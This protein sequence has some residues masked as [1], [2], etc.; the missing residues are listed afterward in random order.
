VED[1]QTRVEVL[2]RKPSE[3]FPNSFLSIIQQA[4]VKKN[5][6]KIEY[7]SYYNEATTQREIEPIGISHYGEGW[8]LIAYCHLRQDY[9]DFRADRIKTLAATGLS[10]KRQHLSLQDYLRQFTSAKQQEEAI[11]LFDQSVVRF[12]AEQKYIYGF[13]KEEQTGKMVR[14]YFRTAYM[15]S[16]GRWLLS[17]GNAVQ[18]EKP[19]RLIEIMLQ[20]AAE[21]HEHYLKGTEKDKE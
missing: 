18:I 16:L 11:V 2:R 17:Y 9:R 21:I 5:C 7:Y 15:E 8:H 6:L 3:A 10:F 14:M 20:L 4:I 19:E 13:Q 1:L 12:M